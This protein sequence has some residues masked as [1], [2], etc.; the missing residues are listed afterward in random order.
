MKED[1]KERKL[2][3]YVCGEVSGEGELDYIEKKQTFVCNK[4]LN[5]Y[6]EDLTVAEFAKLLSTA[7]ARK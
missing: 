3:C 4:C 7:L 1:K 5:T 6:L 2:K